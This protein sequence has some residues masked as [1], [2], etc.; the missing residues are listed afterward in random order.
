MR[1]REVHA[2]FAQVVV[3]GLQQGEIHEHK[4][5]FVPAVEGAGV[6]DGQVPEAS[7]HAHVAVAAEGVADAL[8]AQGDDAGMGFEVGAAVFGQKQRHVV[9]VHAVAELGGAAGGRDQC[10]GGEGCGPAKGA[11]AEPPGPFRIPEPLQG[12]FQ[13]PAFV[14]AANAADPMLHQQA[15][16]GVVVAAAID[17][18]PDAGDGVDELLFEEAQG[19]AQ[20]PVFGMN[21][22]EQSEQH[23][24]TLADLGAPFKSRRVRPGRWR[25][26][27]SRIPMTI[28]GVHA[29][30]NGA[31]NAAVSEMEKSGGFAELFEQE[32]A[33]Q[34][35]KVKV[36][37]RV[38]GVIAHIG[39]DGA[40]VD[41]GGRSQGFY[42]RAGLVDLRGNLKVKVGDTLAGFVT[43]IADD[44]TIE[45]GDRLEK[46][47]SRDHIQA[48]MEAQVPVEGKVVGV[49]KGGAKVDLGGVQAFC[50]KG[51]MDRHFVE[52]LSVFLQQTLRFYVLELK[53][54]GDVVLSRK[55]LLNEEA[56]AAQQEILQRLEPGAR[57]HGKVVRI[58]DFGAF[59]DLGGIDGL[60]P[61]RELSY[62]R[63]RPEQVVSV[64]DAVDVMVLDIDSKKGQPRITLSLKATG[65]DPWAKIDAIAPTGKVVQGVVRRLM[66]FGAFV[67][68]KPGIEGLLHVSELGAGAKHPS[69][70]MNVGD[71]LLV[72]VQSVDPGRKRISLVP[73]PTGA[74]AGATAPSDSVS[75]G[76]IVKATVQS[77]E[78]FG[79]F[80]QIEGTTGRKGRGLIP[81]RELGVSH[82]VDVKKEFPV[83]KEV[84]A[85]IID[86]GRLKLSIKAMKEDEDRKVF[87]QYREKQGNAGMGT[88]G[89]LLK[90]LK[91]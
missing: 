60:I 29:R 76:A 44:G 84:T 22:S 19:P 14:I 1:G 89:D 35:K 88:F 28:A 59:V 82:G 21:I 75:Q 43:G 41:L 50:P 30:A 52:D 85:K 77:V 37:E 32:A 91:K 87:E 71:P 81:E 20:Q 48:A 72:V 74:V 58:R 86:T 39:A 56:A 54:G 9:L 47:V 46:G 3:A 42:P 55:Q 36:G 90:G 69:S 18:V 49:N 73:A 10:R 64:G 15:H 51:Q 78:R 25:G 27:A 33:P 80:V 70:F 16:A 4:A 34:N 79:V 5:G 31:R 7:D 23:P 2:A 26:A 11:P 68:L 8:A 12:R 38:E 61:T 13:V 57:M 17:D 40:F 63:R 6:D 24:G 62:E 45:L 65:E 67:E 66:D 83:G 53:Q